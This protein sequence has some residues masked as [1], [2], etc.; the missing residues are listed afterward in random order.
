MLL[1]ALA[2]WLGILVLASL[3]GALRDLVMAPR[4]GDP[5]ARAI[6]TLLL[7]GLVLLVTWVT[8]P[9]IGPRSRGQA[10]AIGTTWLVC[11]LAFEFL[12]GHYLFRKPWAELLE[13]YD[14]RRGRI[15]IAVLVV[16]FA[17][18]CWVA[19]ARGLEEAW[20]WRIK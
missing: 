20:R 10:I 4:L 2:V 7:S 19:R 18:P 17:A 14:L 1:R 12:A 8:L 6:S 13:D 16:T 9:W 5:L 3:N 15:W 11:T